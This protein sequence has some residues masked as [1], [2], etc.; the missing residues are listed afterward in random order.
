MKGGLVENFFKVQDIVVDVEAGR[1]FEP[2]CGSMKLDFVNMTMQP[3]GARSKL[4][5]IRFNEDKELLYWSTSSWKAFNKTYTPQV[6]EAV[7][8]LIEKNIERNLLG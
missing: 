7:R 8:L 1:L 3:F 2:Y 6:I 4:V 5:P